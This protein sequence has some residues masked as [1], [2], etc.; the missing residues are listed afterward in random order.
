MRGVKAAGRCVLGGSEAHSSR[1]R[2]GA[3]NVEEADGVLD[4]TLGER[5]DDARGG[6]G[7]GHLG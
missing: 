6:S 7:G 3:V 2:E 4:R 1:G 5:G